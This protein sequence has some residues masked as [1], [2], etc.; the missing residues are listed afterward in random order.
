MGRGMVR[1]KDCV[2]IQMWEH[3]ADRRM[4]SEHEFSMGKSKKKFQ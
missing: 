4:L 3:R 2:K 1:R